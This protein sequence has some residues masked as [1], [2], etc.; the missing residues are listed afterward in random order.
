MNTV[1]EYNLG[2]LSEALLDPNPFN[3]F[4]KWF[5]ETKNTDIYE[6]EAMTLS[7][8]SSDGKPSARLVLL[9]GFD[10]NGFCFYSNYLSKKGRELEHNPWTSLT[11]WWDRLERQVRIDGKAKPLTGSESDS[12]FQQRPRGHQINT[13][14]SPQ[15]RVIAN[16]AELE[17]EAE[18]IA[19][20]YQ[21]TPIPRPPNWGGY[22][23]WPMTIEFWQG[24]PNRLHDRLVYQRQGDDTWKI[25]R[26]AP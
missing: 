11:F 24:R 15:S 4:A 6:P 3:Q 7:T 25:M 23:V 1:D 10:D 21:D 20:E 14:A 16:R 17:E 13:W 9:R 5:K 12:Y 26:L 18:V 19:G 8:V 22:R 2:E